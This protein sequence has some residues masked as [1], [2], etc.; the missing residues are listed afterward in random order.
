MTTHNAGP[1]CGV[2]VG[3][4]HV[5]ECDIGRCS[6]CGSQRT[7]CDC[8]GHDPRA[9]AWTGEWP[10]QCELMV[11]LEANT[12]DDIVRQITEDVNEDSIVRCDFC[13]GT[14]DVG[15]DLLPPDYEVTAAWCGI[16]HERLF[17]LPESVDTDRVDWL[18]EGL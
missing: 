18:H 10:D 5:N 9:S 8:E 3:Q 7:I 1:D 6:V 12:R 4:P 2:A 14:E 11:K 13:G 17:R 16:C 15:I